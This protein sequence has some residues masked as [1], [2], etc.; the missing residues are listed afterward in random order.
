MG[1]FSNGDKLRELLSNKEAKGGSSVYEVF[2]YDDFRILASINDGGSQGRELVFPPAFDWTELQALLS[3]LID[4]M[5]LALSD[6]ELSKHPDVDLSGNGPWA[7]MYKVILHVVHPSFT[8]V[9]Q[10]V[11]YRSTKAGPNLLAAT[12]ILVERWPGY[13][14]P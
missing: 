4:V 14:P 3:N 1:K 2:A 5:C 11:C 8:N 9:V 13:L 12:V 10:C 6:P 7:W